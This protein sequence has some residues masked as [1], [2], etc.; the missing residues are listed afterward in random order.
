MDLC[1]SC[2]SVLSR[3][4]FGRFNVM[5]MNLLRSRSRPRESVYPGVHAA[6]SST[7]CPG[8]HE[9][10]YAR[11]DPGSGTFSSTGRNELYPLILEYIVLRSV[12]I[13]NGSLSVENGQRDLLTDTM[14]AESLPIPWRRF[15]PLFSR[16]C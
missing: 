4:H 13:G 6:I 16:L 14:I 1:N 11:P 9:V 15:L 7:R 5:Y 8:R 10:I 2:S 3:V 12:P